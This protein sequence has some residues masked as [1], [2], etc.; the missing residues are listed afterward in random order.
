MKQLNMGDWDKFN[1]SELDAFRAWGATKGH[2]FHIDQMPTIE[3]MKEYLRE[4]GT[5]KCDDKDVQNYSLVELNGQK[6]RA[7]EL[8]YAL[9]DM[10]K[11][12]IACA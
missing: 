5:L 8:C 4:K 7:I 2:R 11:N 6:T 12:K 9:L 10:V 3:Q 1:S